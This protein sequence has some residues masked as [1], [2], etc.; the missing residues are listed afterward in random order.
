ML[1]EN[2]GYAAINFIKWQQEVN[3]H[4]EE[5]F[6]GHGLRFRAAYAARNNA[7]AAPNL[8]AQ[9]FTADAPNRI[10]VSDITFIAIRKGWLYLAVVVDLYSRKA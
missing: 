2:R 7:P 4:A 8:L 6:P 1:P 10:R 5:A 3:A 9:N